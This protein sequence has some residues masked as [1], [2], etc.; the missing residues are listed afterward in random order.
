MV[1]A[2][3]FDHQE[4]TLLVLGQHVHGLG[5]HFRQARFLGRIAV[6]VVTHVAGRKHAE[7]AVRLGRIDGLE[8]GG[9]VGDRVALRLQF[10][11]QVAVVG[12]LAAALEWRK[13]LCA[14]TE[15]HF[16]AG[17]AQRAVVA[18]A[19]RHEG[20]GDIVFQ[21]AVADVRVSRRWRGVRHARRADDAGGEA[22]GLGQF[23]QGG[24][25]R[26]VAGAAFVDQLVAV[27]IR[28]RIDGDRVGRH[29]DDFIVHLD[30]GHVG[31]HRWRAVRHLR[32]VRERL[33]EGRFRQSVHGQ[34]AVFAHRID[35]R[36]RHGGQ[37]HA[38]AKEE[39]DVFRRRFGHHVF[40]F[41]I[42]AAG[43]QHQ[44]N[45]DAAASDGNFSAC[46]VVHPARFERASKIAMQCDTIMTL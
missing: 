17:G 24:G 14:A 32:I 10:G 40:F 13:E 39:D 19:A 34:R 22:L 9:V 2:A 26:A 42:A 37:A 16:Q 15:D 35:A 7:Q 44:G 18:R 5:G 41:G 31:G 8:V 45:G 11:H 46:H 21:V 20:C 38:I 30:A 23:Q 43:G 36:G 27:C 29:R 28:A 6:Q 12:T 1:D 4:I 3:A 33:D 25:G